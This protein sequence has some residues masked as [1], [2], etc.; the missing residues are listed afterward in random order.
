M[1][2]SFHPAIYLYLFLA[3]TKAYRWEELVSTHHYL[4]KI[5]SL[6]VGKNAQDEALVGK[7]MFVATS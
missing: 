2:N 5:I 6:S 7:Y 3:L 4:P 1:L